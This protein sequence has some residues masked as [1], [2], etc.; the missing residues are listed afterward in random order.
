[1]LYSHM[2]SLQD[3]IEL[4]MYDPTC[5]NCQSHD[6]MCNPIDNCCVEF[7]D[8]YPSTRTR[9]SINS[10]P[11]KLV[12]GGLNQIILQSNCVEDTIKIDNI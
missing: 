7:H 3:L 9:K 6:K 2:V 11:H 1:M 8:K 12:L 5:S 10:I 4:C